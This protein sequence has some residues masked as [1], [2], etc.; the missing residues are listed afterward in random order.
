MVCVWHLLNATAF[1]WSYEIEVNVYIDY[2][3][4]DGAQLTG[5]RLLTARK[6]NETQLQRC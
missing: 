2:T 1:K 3:I 5:S 6:A 4:T